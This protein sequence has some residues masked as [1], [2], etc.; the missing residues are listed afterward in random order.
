[1]QDLAL[2]SDRYF[3][4]TISLDAPVSYAYPEQKGLSRAGGVTKDK[5]IVSVVNRWGQVPV[6]VET[7]IAIQK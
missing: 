2:F 6:A 7:G 4:L 5:L 3:D 1:M